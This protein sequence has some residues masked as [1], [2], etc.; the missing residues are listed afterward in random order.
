[1][2]F[3][4]YSFRFA[5]R[6]L[7]VTALIWSNTSQGQEQAAGLDA[8]IARHR[9][10]VLE[11]RTT[12]NTDIRVEQQ[13]HE[14]WFG[15]ALANEAFDGRM[16]AADREKYLAVFLTNFNA[17]VTENALKWH[18]M[19]RQ[20][21][22]VRY[23]T[24]DS[25]LSWTDQNKIPLR[26]H[27]IFWGV[28]DQVQDW[29][30]ELPNDAFREALKARALDVGR[31]Y[32]GRF[33][34]YD[35]NNE[36]IH[37]NY[38]E[39]RLGPGITRE[40]ADWVR[41]ADPDAK[42]FLNDYNILTG[43]QLEDYIKHIRRLLDQKVPIGGIGVQGHF[44]GET[45][46]RTKLHE[47]LTRLSEFNLPIRVTEF[48]MPGQVSKYYKDRSL[49]LSE[50]QETAKARELVDY[51]RICFSYPQVQG[52]LMWGFWEGANWIPV[53]SMYKRDW[54]PLPAAKAYHDLVYGEWWTRFSGKTDAQG[55]CEVPAFYGEHKVS[56]GDKSVQV[57]LRK[58]DGRK[59]VE[60]R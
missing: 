46:D 17:A 34:E 18:D 10:G 14:F 27:N 30:K 21:G 26:G 22:K 15:A 52:M 54:T 1:M 29:L 40:M 33:A 12:P 7:Y 16:P 50:A 35:L 38:Y 24:V 49:R 42:L 28:P 9:K 47:A 57:T 45:F 13:R 41:E 60:L 39:E 23:T 36:M 53:S 31:R 19:E 37:G 56:A 25:I 4:A 2:R 8:A 59:T 43:V 44:H 32:K 58:S 6:I 11:I 51:Y 3:P 55:H 20:K 5:V 48:N